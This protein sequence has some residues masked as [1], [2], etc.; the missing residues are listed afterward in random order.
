MSRIGK[1]PIDVPKGVTVTISDEIVVKGP[2]GTLQRPVVDGITVVQD[3]AQLVCTRSDDSRTQRA[4]HGLMRALLNNMVIGVTKG[5]EK[6]LEVH[7]VGYRAELKGTTLVLQVGY[8]HPI[9]FP[10]PAGISFDVDKGRTK[11]KV[12]GIDKEQVGQAAAVIRGFRPPDSYK[13]KGIRYAGEHIR[14][15]AGKSAKS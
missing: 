8:S 15:K 6:D 2:K 1:L 13:G 5:F 12:L 14:L 9:E 4:N 3:G 11:I 10:A 7:G